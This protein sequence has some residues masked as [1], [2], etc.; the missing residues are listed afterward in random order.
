MLWIWLGAAAAVAAVMIPLWGPLRVAGHCYAL[1]DGAEREQAQVVGKLENGSFALQL[2]EGSH[3]GQS[4]TAGTSGAIFQA[5]EPGDVLEVV[6]VTWK[7]GEC[8]LGSTIEASGRVLWLLSGVL[9][10]LVS[11]IVLLTAGLTRSFTRPAHP[12]RRMQA[13]PRA[14]RCPACG[15][16][17]DEGYLPLVG[18]I[19]W[20]RPGEPVG[21]PHALRGLPGTVGFRGRPRLH[22]FRCVPC[23]IVS[24]QYGESS[25]R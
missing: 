17:M 7:P 9:V 10:A 4:C 19:H 18:G 6:V 25:S 22:A 15:K 12:A 3:A 5:T 16:A 13:D 23:E 2:V 24:F 11:G 1:H 8:E 14:V 20:R 21:L